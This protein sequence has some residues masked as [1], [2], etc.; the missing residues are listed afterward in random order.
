MGRINKSD[1]IS[2]LITK[3]FGVIFSGYLLASAIHP[4]EILIGSV[5]ILGF[6]FCNI[7]GKDDEQCQN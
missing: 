6:A 4:V 1:E 3:I 5:L 2:L 7:G